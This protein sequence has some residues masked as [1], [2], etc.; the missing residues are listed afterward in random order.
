[1]GFTGNAQIFAPAGVVRYAFDLERQPYVTPFGEAGLGF[2]ISHHRGHDTH[3]SGLILFG[4]GVEYRIRENLGVGGKGY[5]N[6]APGPGEDFFGS[7]MGGV[8]WYY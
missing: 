8:T 6:F 1:M 7:L 4:G 3:F 2:L 5:L